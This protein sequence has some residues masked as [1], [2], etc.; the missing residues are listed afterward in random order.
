MKT[1]NL[2]NN[3]SASKGVFKNADGT[4]LALSF[5]RS[6]TFKTEKGALKWLSQ[7]S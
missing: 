6:K 5:S 7:K 1:L 2:G 3:E 4:F